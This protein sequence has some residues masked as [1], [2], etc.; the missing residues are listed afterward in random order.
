M[1]RVLFFALWLAS[2]Q[3][4]CVAVGGYS[5]RGGWFFWP[6]GLLL[7]VLLALVFLF[8]RRRR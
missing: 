1:Q 3:L 5:N 6:G 4:S 2:S 7:F 8:I